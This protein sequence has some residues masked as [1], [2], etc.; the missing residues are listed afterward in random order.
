MEFSSGEPLAWTCPS[1]TDGAAAADWSGVPEGRGGVNV[2]AG[3]FV[4]FR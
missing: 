3:C 2:A 4:A 1:N